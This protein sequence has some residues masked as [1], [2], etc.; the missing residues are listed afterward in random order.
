MPVVDGLSA[1]REAR[2]RGL[3]L[4][5]VAVTANV[6]DGDRERCLASGMNDYLAKP[7][8]SEALAAMIDRWAGGPLVAAAA[9]A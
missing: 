3:Q 8:T 2:D 5:I 6:L 7:F 9:S 1:T 4:P